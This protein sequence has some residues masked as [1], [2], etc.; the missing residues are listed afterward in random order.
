MSRPHG[1]SEEKL[2][3]LATALDALERKNVPPAA[4]VMPPP[5]PPQVELGPKTKLAIRI[6]AWGFGIYWILWILLVALLLIESPRRQISD[7][8]VV[9]F[10]ALVCWLIFHFHRMILI[11]VVRKVSSS[12]AAFV[13]SKVIRGRWCG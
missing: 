13:A 11:G 2:R 10:S 12:R 1:S 4:P 7:L 9:P 5:K 6:M 8:F 3:E